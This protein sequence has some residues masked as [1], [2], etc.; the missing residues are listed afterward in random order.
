MN[1]VLA[2]EDV[3]RVVI[4][5]LVV[6]IAHVITVILLI[7]IIIIVTVMFSDNGT[8]YINTIYRCG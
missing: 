3:S 6:T 2:M 5:L 1:V 8:Y 4:T 7:L